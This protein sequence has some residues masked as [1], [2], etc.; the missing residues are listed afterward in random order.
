M[1]NIVNKLGFRRA[2]KATE[3]DRWVVRVWRGEKE[4]QG[5]KIAHSGTYESCA[6]FARRVSSFERNLYLE[7]GR[8]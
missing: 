4:A 5:Y 2:W 8:K 3:G 1:K 7:R 6:H